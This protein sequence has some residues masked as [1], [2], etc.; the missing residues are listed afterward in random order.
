MNARTLPVVVACLLAMSL[1]ALADDWPQWQG[2]DRNNVSKETGL[3]KS[4]PGGG[5]KLLWSIDNLGAGYAGP[6]VVSD[7]LYVLG[8]RGTT[9]YVFALDANSHRE[10]WTA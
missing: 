10:V 4:W 3:L 6:A 9:E 8:M 5:P 7:R 1:P 2:P